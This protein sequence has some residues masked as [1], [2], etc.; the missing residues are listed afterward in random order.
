MLKEDKGDFLKQNCSFQGRKN[1]KAFVQRQEGRNKY[2]HKCLLLTEAQIW[3]L[4]RQRKCISNPLA[5]PCNFPT[6]KCWAKQ[7]T[8]PIFFWTDATFGAVSPEHP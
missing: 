7:P 4:K 2:S 8:I 3:D 6:V 1:L 5:L